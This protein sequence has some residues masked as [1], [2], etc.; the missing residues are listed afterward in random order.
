MEAAAVA[1]E[2]HRIVV[3][4]N[5]LASAFHA[6]WNKGNNNLDSRFI[7]ETDPSL[8]RAR[9]GLIS[10]VRIIISGGLE[11]LLGITPQYEMR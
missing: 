5:D 8:T 11:T 2:P 6:L 1:Y 9:L 3:Y 4:L 7:V 10:A